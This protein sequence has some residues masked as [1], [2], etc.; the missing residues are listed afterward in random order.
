MGRSRRRRLLKKSWAGGLSSCQHV[1]LQAAMACWMFSPICVQR[2]I[3][4]FRDFTAN[5]A[6]PLLS[7]LYGEES[8]YVMQC[9]EQKPLNSERNCGPPSVLM[10]VDQPKSLN[11]LSRSEMTAFVSSFLS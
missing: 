9:E 11:Q 2:V 5:S 1:L 6:S 8:S 7:W 3:M 4:L 10:C